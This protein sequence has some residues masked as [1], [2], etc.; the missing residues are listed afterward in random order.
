M[1]DSE[2]AGLVLAG[3]LGRRHGGIDKGWLIHQ[4]RPLVAHALAHLQQAGCS[5]RLVSANRNHA[6]YASLGVTVVP[7]RRA[8]FLGPL[9]GIESAFLACEAPSLYVVPVDVLGMPGDWLAQ[10]YSQ[11][12]ATGQPWCGTLDGGRLQ[13]LL[14]VWSR[15]LL[16]ALQAYLDA[17]GRRVMEFVRPWQ[18]HALALPAGIQL[19]NLNVPASLQP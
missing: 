3:G 4:G 8:G 1:M 10:V 11:L 15:A 14:G 17:G 7:D 6:G 13:P 12:Q 2:V 16:P 18:A 9:S 5:P 19:R